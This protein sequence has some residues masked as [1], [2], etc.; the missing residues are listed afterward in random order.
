MSLNHYSATGYQQDLIKILRRQLPKLEDE[1][2]GTEI[3]EA[4]LNRQLFD[5]HLRHVVYR[6]DFE[7]ED[8]D[9]L[10][11]ETA[12]ILQ[13]KLK[14]LC[15]L[16]NTST[17][18]NI[19]SPTQSPTENLASSDIHSEEAGD[20]RR[21]KQMLLLVDR[22]KGPFQLAT[23]DKH[24]LFRFDSPAATRK[25]RTLVQDFNH[26]LNNIYQNPPLE[27]FHTAT[28]NQRAT[29]VW[30]H[31]IDLQYR[32]KMGKILDSLHT[33][34]PKCETSDTVNSHKV[35]IQLIDSETMRQPVS[36]LSLDLF[37]FCPSPEQEQWHNILCRF[38]QNTII[39]SRGDITL[40][41]LLK[42][43]SDRSDGL[44]LVFNQ[45]QTDFTHQIKELSSHNRT[46]NIK[47][48]DLIN[49][50]NAF[51]V[52]SGK[53]LDKDIFKYSERRTLAAKLALNLL[54]FCAWQH[55]SMSWDD[56]EIF[57]LGS[58]PSDYEKGKSY[59][60]CF[61]GRESSADTRVESLVADPMPSFTRFAKLLLELEYGP[62]MNGDYSEKTNY[63]YNLVKDFYKR[64][65][66][67]GDQSR[68]SYL[69]AVQTCLDFDRI[70]VQERCKLLT[71]LETEDETCRRIIRT[72]IVENIMND[73]DTSVQRRLK[74]HR[75]MS[76][77]SNPDSNSS[78]DQKFEGTGKH[79]G[80]QRKRM[81]N[82][83]LASI[84]S[85][86]PHGTREDSRK[87]AEHSRT[88]VKSGKTPLN[89][90]NVQE[91]R[92]KIVPRE[93]P[94]YFG[95]HGELM[96]KRS[97]S[98]ASA[99]WFEKFDNL[100]R[101]LTATCEETDKRYEQNRVKI[102]VIDSGLNA[103]RQN[104][105]YITYRNFI[106]DEKRNPAFRDDPQHGTDSVDLIRKIYGRAHI[107]VAKVFQATEADA[108]TSTY[109]AHAVQWA[110]EQEV[111]IISISAGFRRGE[112]E[113]LSRKIEEAT[114]GGDRP[115][116]LVFAAA[117]NSQNIHKVAFPAN[118][119]DRVFCIFCCNGGLVHS[120]QWNPSALP[121]PRNFAMLGEDVELHSGRTLAG[122]T[123]ISTALVAGLA[124]KL[125]DF[126]RQP[127][128]R[129]R[130]TLL[131]RKMQKRAGMSLIFRA[132]ASKGNDGYQYLE[133]WE[134]L[135]DLKGRSRSSVREGICTIIEKAVQ[136][137]C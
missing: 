29:H 60:E 18:D 4:F 132:I 57:F 103:E 64:E 106:P 10:P 99:T 46:P 30:A 117:S 113:Y 35:L 112:N 121:S 91:H 15:Q 82:L 133:P 125:L 95:E 44:T 48:L 33:E 27:L 105:A 71:Q 98:T 78:N 26:F 41:K 23:G 88:D 59:I 128:V 20:F 131:G 102:A 74:H 68:I 124:A 70:Y 92:P 24:S 76:S 101:F 93:A 104:D 107:Y 12:E 55:S 50:F 56:S 137:I 13:E 14:E 32:A 58:S 80:R 85:E 136:Y 3:D 130:R 111:N 43:Y 115:E 9:L 73:L 62:L 6:N 81:K 5:A 69:T 77:I 52:P 116:I 8:I 100:D 114:A 89:I 63:G 40:C 38:K 110:I 39:H 61:L 90:I 118:M 66:K 31:A 120:R 65:M 54:T 97:V 37:L 47:L 123:S 83:A 16:L 19:Q 126:S 7:D 84:C 49:R 67:Y 22:S 36:L 34:F 87:R 28:K 75:R 109:M 127:Q 135:P 119:E 42:S 129:D 122:G 25:A 1:E 21:L 72:R 11:F 86:N 108:N 79:F 94:Q 53:N 96:L 45:T 17:N 51:E 2:E 134:I